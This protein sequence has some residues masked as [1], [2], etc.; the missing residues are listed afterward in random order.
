MKPARKTDR[1]YQVTSYPLKSN[2]AQQFGYNF[3]QWITPFSFIDI[4][5]QN[6]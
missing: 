3:N 4:L 1:K 2:G 5:Y 6:L